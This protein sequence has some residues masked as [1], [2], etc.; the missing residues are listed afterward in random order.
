MQ[1]GAIG[2]LMALRNLMNRTDVVVIDAEDGT[3]PW[4]TPSVLATG[5]GRL[6]AVAPESVRPSAGG[7]ATA[8]QRPRLL[9][10]CRIGAVH[11]TSQHPALS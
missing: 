8:D 5:L 10:N 7:T 11:I 4:R 6:L 9:G 3:A 1:V 2:K